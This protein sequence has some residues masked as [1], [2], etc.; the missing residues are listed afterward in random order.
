MMRQLLAGLIM[1]F[2]AVGMAFAALDINTATADEFD[3]LKGIGPVKAK[4]IVEFRVKNGPFRSIED[5]KNVPGIGDS[6]FDAIKREITVGAGSGLR[7]GKSAESLRRSERNEAMG[8]PSMSKGDDRAAG[9]AAPKSEMGKAEV[10]KAKAE[11]KSDGK[12]KSSDAP[13]AEAG[14]AA[15]GKS[16]R[17]ETR[18]GERPGERK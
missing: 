18:S 17:A 1:L 13:R 16:E 15:A 9:K 7:A 12:A 3:K 11:A 10:G 14:A 6:T 2:C 5:L 4:A 8:A